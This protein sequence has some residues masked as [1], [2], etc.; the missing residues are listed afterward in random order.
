MLA[1]DGDEL[2]CHRAVLAS[3]SPVMDRMLSSWLK[4]GKEMRIVIRD[5]SP[6]DLLTFVMYIYTERLPVAWDVFALLRL[7][8]LYDIPKLSAFCVT[9]LAKHVT[10]SNVVRTLATLRLYQN[11]MDVRDCFDIIA[12]KVRSGPVSLSLA[13]AQNSLRGAALGDHGGNTLRQKLC[14]SLAN[15]VKTVTRHVRSVVTAEV[16]MAAETE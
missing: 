13:L 4:E 11:S 5:V 6:E 2:H 8:D 1:E 9:H 15:D 14:E 3:A 7:A 12:K 10:G 16:L